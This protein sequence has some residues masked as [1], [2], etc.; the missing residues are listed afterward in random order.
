M[1]PLKKLT[2]KQLSIIE[3]M[4]THPT[5]T[6]AEIAREFSI[7]PAA[8]TN[9]CKDALFSAEL[10]KRLREEWKSSVG[11]AQQRMRELLDA[12]DSRVRLDAAKY[13][14]SSCGYTAP[15]DVNVSST[16]IKIVV[17]PEDSDS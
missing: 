11:K 13:I 9:F 8:I 17:K 15:V 4:V 2:A 16:E 5:M 1:R 7:T 10:E 14:L 12:S 3:F 6:K